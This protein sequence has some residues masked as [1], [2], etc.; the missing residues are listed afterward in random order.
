LSDL[1][2]ESLPDFLGVL[3]RGFLE[4]SSGR[5]AFGLRLR[6]GLLSGDSDFAADESASELVLLVDCFFEDFALVLPM[7]N[8]GNGINGFP[9]PKPL[10]G[11]GLRPRQACK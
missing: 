5:L 7:P 9:R 2:P 4:L 10:R 11:R 6:D 1:V 8:N 3:S